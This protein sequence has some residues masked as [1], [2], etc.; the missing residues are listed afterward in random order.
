MMSIFGRSET[1]SSPSTKHNHFV[2]DGYI[3]PKHRQKR[4]IPS[5]AKMIKGGVSPSRPGSRQHRMPPSRE[6]STP[7]S[8]KSAGL[9]SS[10]SRNQNQNVLPCAEF[11]RPPSRPDTPVDWKATQRKMLQNFDSPR[12]V[13]SEHS[14]PHGFQSQSPSPHPSTIYK[15]PASPRGILKSDSPR[16][17]LKSNSPGGVRKAQSP[18]GILKS[19]SPRGVLKSNFTKGILKKSSELPKSPPTSRPRSPPG[20]Q[21]CDMGGDGEEY[22]PPPSRQKKAPAKNYWL[23]PP[24]SDESKASFS[25]VMVAD[26]YDT[27]DQHLWKPH[28]SS[29][30]VPP[31][32][33]ARDRPKMRNPNIIFN[34][35]S[36][37]AATCSSQQCD[38]DEEDDEPDESCR[39][40]YQPCAAPLDWDRDPVLRSVEC[41][42]RQAYRQRKLE[43]Y[44]QEVC[45]RQKHSQPPERF[46]SYLIRCYAYA[47]G[48]LN[49]NNSKHILGYVDGHLSPLDVWVLRLCRG[50]IS[51]LARMGTAFPNRDNELFLR[52]LREEC[53]AL[54]GARGSLL[55][56]HLNETERRLN[57]CNEQERNYKKI[58]L[59]SQR[60]PLGVMQYLSRRDYR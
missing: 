41:G 48:E 44:L 8:I 56:R 28:Y 30:R 38:D 59:L 23:G 29:G 36:D 12:R 57:A 19:E 52:I 53:V 32:K 27:R 16:G 40:V 2:P 51:R 9:P 26:K 49:S 10:T 18:K 1:P 39:K 14:I 60:S 43:E 22:T 11:S 46:E 33:S 37:S 4:I 45:A 21:Y 35:V 58:L 25:P 55:R 17:I 47:N 20:N 15:K 34:V 24:S 42:E 50:T 31:A 13:I 54:D 3:P 6:P 5:Y 7:R